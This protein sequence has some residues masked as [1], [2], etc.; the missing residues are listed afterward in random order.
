MF[1]PK[2]E[3][4]TVSQYVT[5]AEKTV[6]QSWATQKLFIRLI[7]EAKV[8]V[9]KTLKVYLSEKWNKNSEPVRYHRRKNSEPI[10]SQSWATHFWNYSWIGWLFLVRKV[11]KPSKYKWY[12]LWVSQ[13]SKIIIISFWII[14]DFGPPLTPF[15]GGDPL[16]T[17]PPYGRSRTTSRAARPGLPPPGSPESRASRSIFQTL[18]RVFPVF[19]VYLINTLDRVFPV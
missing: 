8:C 11:R 14:S 3:I 15:V 17:A 5:I 2:S 4:K 19:P 9:L 1:Y 7:K 12:H 13:Y 18:D 6:S 16:G 10:M